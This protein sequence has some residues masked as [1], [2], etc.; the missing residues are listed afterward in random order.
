MQEMCEVNSSSCNSLSKKEWCQDSGL[1]DDSPADVRAIS[2]SL[3]DADKDDYALWQ[4]DVCTL[5]EGPFANLKVV[6]IGGNVKKRARAGNLAMALSVAGGLTE[7][8][9]KEV[10]GSTFALLAAAVRQEM[11]KCDAK[12]KVP[13]P[14]LD[15]T[16]QGATAQKEEKDKTQEDPFQDWFKAHCSEGTKEKGLVSRLPPKPPPRRDQGSTVHNEKRSPP[17]PPPF[18]PPAELA[19]YRNTTAVSNQGSGTRS[20]SASSD[21]SE[22]VMLVSPSRIA[23]SPGV[24]GDQPASV[25]AAHR[26]PA[27]AWLSGGTANHDG[28]QVADDAVRHALRSARAPMDVLSIATIGSADTVP[29]G[30]DLDPI[31]GYS[32]LWAAGQVADPHA[33]ALLQSALSLRVLD[34]ENLGFT[35]G[36][37]VPSAKSGF[38][39]VGVKKAVQHFLTEGLKVIVVGKRAPMQDAL[40]GEISSGDCDVL[41][42]DNTDDVFVLRAAYDR[43]CPVVSRDNFKAHVNDLRIDRNLRNWWASRGKTLQVKFT[44]DCNGNFI[45][46]YDLQMPV[47]K[48]VEH[49]ER[50]GFQ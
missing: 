14:I 30:T 23:T 47:L 1:S 42:A 43:G 48:P 40:S 15:Q 28:C 20:S 4:F 31:N 7:P 16:A 36:E 45:P 39:M 44:F 11:T 12:K 10:C 13:L 41:L 29:L 32:N 33:K 2:A 34:A 25:A 26:S 17:P 27:E 3:R 37:H 19:N 21:S 50:R 22:K 9:R 49:C 38:H 35:Y 8:C 46:D 6:A 18:P 24:R 5:L